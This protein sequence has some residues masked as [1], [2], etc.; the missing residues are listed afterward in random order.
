MT[1]KDYIAAARI[2]NQHFR[3]ARKFDGEARYDAERAAEQTM[4]A[5][6]AFFTQ[7]GGRFMANRFREACKEGKS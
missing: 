6:V 7:D 2:V 5:F 4:E 3:Q 1:K